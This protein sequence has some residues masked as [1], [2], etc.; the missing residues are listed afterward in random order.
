MS[1]SAPTVA[2]SSS[3]IQASSGEYPPFSNM[4]AAPPVPP[5]WWSDMVGD[6]VAIPA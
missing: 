1:A 5:K 2:T 4:F 3:P 6:V